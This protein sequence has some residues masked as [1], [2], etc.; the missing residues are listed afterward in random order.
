MHDFCH[1]PW[2]KAMLEA[3]RGSAYSVLDA[4]DLPPKFFEYLF[5]REELK[6]GEALDRWVEKPTAGKYCPVSP[7]S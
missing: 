2:R 3:F 6:K 1:K 4:E 5:D 7:E